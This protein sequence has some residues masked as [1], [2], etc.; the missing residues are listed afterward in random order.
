MSTVAKVFVVLNL[1]LAVAFMIFTLTLYAHRVDWKNKFQVEEDARKEDVARLEAV[2]AQRDDSIVKL[3]KDLETA[4]NEKKIAQSAN[5]EI[6]DRWKSE[7]LEKQRLH[8]RYEALVGQLD[9]QRQA[10][11][12]QADDL[13]KAL[14]TIEGQQKFVEQAKRNNAELERQRAEALAQVNRLRAELHAA[15]SQR[16]HEAEELAQLRYIMSKL[17]EKNVPIPE[18]VGDATEGPL[19]HPIRGRVVAVRPGQHFVALSVGLDDGVRKGYRFSVYRSEGGPETAQFVA[20][21]K[22]QKVMADHCG[23]VILVPESKGMPKEGDEALCRG[24]GA[25]PYGTY[26]TH[27]PVGVI[28]TVPQTAP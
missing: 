9:D 8:V 7:L 4:I 26:G 20:R 21:V 24:F 12:R 14:E 3:T 1:V 19:G 23:C 27:E 18:L 10:Y 6:I 17:N 16:R 25:A 13:K 11:R 2:I 22:V 28:G 15:Q 5:A